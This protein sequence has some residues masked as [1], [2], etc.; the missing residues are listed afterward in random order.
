MT[1]G[2]AVG[3]GRQATIAYINL[4]CYYVIGLPFGILMGW[5]FDLGIM[6][7][8][9]LSIYAIIILMLAL[10]LLFYLRVGLGIKI[11]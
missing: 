2:V 9:V 6:V 7:I 5:V 10:L 3:S 11:K 1:T 4:G 8:C